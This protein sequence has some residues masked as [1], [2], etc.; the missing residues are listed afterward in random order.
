MVGRT[1]GRGSERTIVSSDC[2]RL[3]RSKQEKLS[4]HKVLSDQ[5]EHGEERGGKAKNR[6]LLAII[7]NLEL[8]KIRCLRLAR[9][10]GMF[11]VVVV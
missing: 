2:K 7:F 9:R 6:Q 8:M 5:V 11:K 4:R 3:L 1:A 10:Q